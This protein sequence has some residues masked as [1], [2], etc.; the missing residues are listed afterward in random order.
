MKHWLY[1]SLLLATS[2]IL[3]QL[4]DPEQ[5][6]NSQEQIIALI[7]NSGKSWSGILNP[8]QRQQ[9][10]LAEID[11]YLKNQSTE[12]ITR[13][14]Q[15]NTTSLATLMS[16][17][18]KVRKERE[19]KAQTLTAQ[20]KAEIIAGAALA[21]LGAGAAVFTIISYINQSKNE[22]NNK[23]DFNLLASLAG[24]IG[25]SGSGWWMIY[26][27][28]MNPGAQAELAHAA[29]TELHLIEAFNTEQQKIAAQKK[30]KKKKQ[31]KAVFTLE[32]E[33]EE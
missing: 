10:T 24:E 22:D 23:D 16:V 8:R 28:W 7:Q 25:S 27:G 30:H 15:D 3:C 32:E 1:L 21:L 14:R 19:L 31:K 17:A 18:E 5:P 20:S 6:I 9:A 33:S 11:A 12:S 2:S 26:Q 29:Q 13:G 4:V